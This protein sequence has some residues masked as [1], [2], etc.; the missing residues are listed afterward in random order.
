MKRLDFVKKSLMGLAALPAGSVLAEKVKKTFSRKQVGF[1]HLPKTG[2][3]KI[4][5][6]TLH[7]SDSRGLANHGWLESRHT[8]SFANYYNQDRVHFGALRV[9]NDDIVQGGM[10]FGTHPHENMEIISIP[11]SGDLEHKDST[12]RHK[13]IK[14]DDVQIM[15]A[16]SGI[17]HSEY[18]ANKEKLVNFLQIWV[19]PKEKN[20]KPRYDQKSYSSAD[21]V[22]KFQTVVA[23]DDESA[24]WIN[25]DAW[26]SLGTLKAGFE[27]K[28]DLHK[29]GSGIYAFIIEG[30][31]EVAGQKL[32]KRDGLTIEDADALEIKAGKDTEI[33][34]MEIPMQVQA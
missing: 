24:V 3:D 22:N 32:S 27:G 1:E 14:Q 7:T 29:E 34:L 2:K 15:S 25:Q 9:L 28:Y 12:G 30:E 10:G 5:K 26:F 16:G 11:L 13:I 23:P 18:N 6:T 21:R 4:M 8:F 31:A 20:I 17:M 33:L 19:F